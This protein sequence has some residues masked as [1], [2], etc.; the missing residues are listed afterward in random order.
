[1][2]D[3]ALLA[4]AARWP[5][6]RLATATASGEIDLVPITFALEG[7]TLVTAVDHKPKRTRKLRRLENIAREPRVT[8][9]IDRY[10]DDWASLWW[11]RLRGIAIV[12][13]EGPGFTDAIAQLV[14][15]YPRHYS[16][17][18]PE[19]PVIRVDITD[20]RVWQSS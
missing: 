12:V 10:D 3:D 1:M 20:V 6:A 19:G 13:S 14:E 17:V 2:D 15:K 5:V 9:L 16:Q 18:P 8:V 11:V 7:S 4:A